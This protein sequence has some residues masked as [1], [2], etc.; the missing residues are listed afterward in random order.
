ME[1]SSITRDADNWIQVNDEAKPNCGN[2]IIQASENEECDCG[3]DGDCL[4]PPGDDLNGKQCT[5]INH[6]PPFTG[7]QLDCYDAGYSSQQCEF[8]TSQCTTGGGGG[9][10]NPVCGDGDVEGDE[11]CD[12]PGS[13]CSNTNYL[14]CNSNCKRCIGLDGNTKTILTRTPCRD[15]GNGD[16][17]G[18]YDE[19]IVQV[20]IITNQAIPGTQRT[21]P[22]ECTLISEVDI[23]FFTPL[24]VLMVLALISIYYFFV[25]TKNKKRIRKV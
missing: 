14:V 20:N 5:G 23:P 7:G 2:G 12:P 24:N 19:T 8:D 3:P 25:K 21:T 16:N 6:V 1:D 15:D 17:V 11:G 10:G 22:K 9:P 18:V 4:N 13:Y